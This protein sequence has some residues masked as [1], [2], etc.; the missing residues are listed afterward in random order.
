MNK[1]I[2]ISGILISIIFSIYITQFLGNE[3]INEIAEMEEERISK[4]DPNIDRNGNQIPDE[5]EKVLPEE[6]KEFSNK[7]W[8]NCTLP[9]QIK[10]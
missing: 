9:T 5:L 7:D 4:C 1:G 8:S 3:Q 10:N 2:I 6:L